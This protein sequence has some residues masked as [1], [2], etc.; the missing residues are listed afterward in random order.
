[1]GTHFSFTELNLE[2]NKAVRGTRPR[3]LFNCK[4]IQIT[5]VLAKSRHNTSSRLPCLTYIRLC[6]R[7]VTNFF[8]VHESLCQNEMI[9]LKNHPNKTV[10][11]LRFKHSQ[12]ECFQDAMHWNS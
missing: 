11:I 2:D 9:F 4:V 1:M 7:S 8:A 6:G 12:N 10:T 3:A 5:F